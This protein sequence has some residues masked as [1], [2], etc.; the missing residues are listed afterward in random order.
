MPFDDNAILEMRSLGVASPEQ[1]LPPVRLRLAPMLV[2]SHGLAAGSPPDLSRRGH[3][4]PRLS[5]SL[6]E[7]QAGNSPTRDNGNYRA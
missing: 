5:V 7:G 1:G 3:L 2:A 6:L 4:R